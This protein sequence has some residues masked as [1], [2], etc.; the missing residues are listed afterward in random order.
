MDFRQFKSNI[1][2]SLSTKIA[3]RLEI[4]KRE[5]AEKFYSCESS[6][7]SSAEV[8]ANEVLKAIKGKVP[9]TPADL[10]TFDAEVTKAAK[11]YKLTPQEIT[12]KLKPL[13]I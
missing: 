13:T 5:I 3:D 6:G 8:A 1:L 10:I 4:R 9:K 11:K 2:Q 7:N 12:D